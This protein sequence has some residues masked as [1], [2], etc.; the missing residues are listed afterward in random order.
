MKKYYYSAKKSFV[1]EEY[2]KND[3][4]ANVLLLSGRFIRIIRFNPLLKGQSL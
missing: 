1:I 3:R 2:E 4:L